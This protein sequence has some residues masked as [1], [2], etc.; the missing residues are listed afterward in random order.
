MS[1]S[2]RKFML[3]ALAVFGSVVPAVRAV[4]H[5]KPGHNH[6]P[7]P[8]PSPSPSPTISPSPTP[9][10][11]PPPTNEVFGPLGG[12]QLIRDNAGARPV[13]A[14]TGTTFSSLAD[15]NQK[16]QSGKHKILVAD[17]EKDRLR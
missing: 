15:L 8:S 16:Y 10:P 7:K 1:L 9:T 12:A 5:H 3:G 6:G 14:P 17:P 4:A 2:R 13:V 11:T